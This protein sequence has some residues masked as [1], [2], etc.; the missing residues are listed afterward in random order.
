M[1]PDQL[2]AFSLIQPLTQEAL[3]GYG[4]TCLSEECLNT[5][6]VPKTKRSLLSFDKP[7]L[8]PSRK[9]VCGGSV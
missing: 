6:E 9:E 7:K 1:N 8:S 2:L 3:E 4:P 5:S